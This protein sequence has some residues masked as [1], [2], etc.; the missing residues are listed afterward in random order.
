MPFHF[1]HVL[2]YVYNY[3]SLFLLDVEDILDVFNE[4]V[5]VINEFLREFFKVV[6]VEPLYKFCRISDG[7]FTI[8]DSLCALS[9]EICASDDCYCVENYGK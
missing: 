9:A 1:S 5:Q 4:T 8:C 3:T 6:G 7:N 2:L